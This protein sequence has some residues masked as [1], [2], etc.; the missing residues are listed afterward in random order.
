MKGFAISILDGDGLIASMAIG[1]GKAGFFSFLTLIVHAISQVEGKIGWML[2][3]PPTKAL[4]KVWL[5][6]LIDFSIF[7][8]LSLTSCSN[9]VTR[10]SLSA[11]IH[12]L[13]THSLRHIRSSK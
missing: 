2:V 1:A 11:L 7:T 3:I 5:I 9:R 12:W 6:L 10:W 13:S 4:P 8:A